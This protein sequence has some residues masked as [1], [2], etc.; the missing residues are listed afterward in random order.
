MLVEQ[1]LM[2]DAIEP[3][4]MQTLEETPVFVHAG[5][6]TDSQPSLHLACARQCS[7]HCWPMIHGDGQ[8]TARLHCFLVAS[9]RGFSFSTKLQCLSS[10]RPSH[11]PMV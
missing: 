9:N 1:V 7:D 6:A 10:A 3:T 5:A 8:P 2:K 4:L 11:E